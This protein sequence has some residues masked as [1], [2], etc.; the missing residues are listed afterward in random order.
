MASRCTVAV[1]SDIHY[2]GD[3]ERARRRHESAV[4]RQRALRLLARTF[5]HYF[6][7]RDPFAHNELLDRFLREADGADW[8]VANG[9]YSCDSAFIGVCDDAACASAAACLDRLRARFP[10]R[11]AATYGD[12]ELGKMSLFGGRGGP[13]LASWRRA[14]AELGLEP[15]WQRDL[16]NYR[17][18]GVVSSLVAL[19]VY[20]PE[21][22]P[23]EQAEWQALRA[24]HL[25]QIARA[26]ADL[27]PYQRVLLFCHDPTALPFLWQEETVRA[28]LAQVEC[29]I[30]GHLHTPLIY[31]KSRLLAGM[32][33]VSCLGN[34]IR[35][36]SRALHDARLWGPFRVRLC[37][38]LAGC[39][40]LKDGGY[41][42]LELDLAARAPVGI[43]FHPLPWSAGERQ[44]HG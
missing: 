39:Q 30:I 37:P 32:P 1:V 16:G 4:I 41:Y 31:W 15:F 26:F 25:G 27:A 17:L 24:T 3:A 2:A 43:T 13:R 7:M 33:T 42:T 22:L 9:D 28:K 29:T 21:V 35:R 40:L 44:P 5:R 18:F 23:E 6:W 38:A 10:G 12:H 19:P 36:M 34:S 11:M 20:A 8:L 14:Q